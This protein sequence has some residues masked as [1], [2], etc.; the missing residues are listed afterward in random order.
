MGTLGREGLALVMPR[1]ASP[2]RCVLSEWVCHYNAGRPHVALGPGM[3]QPSAA[4]PV[5]LQ[6]YR[7]QLPTHGR[8]VVHPILG[9]VYYEDARAAQAACSWSYK[10][11]RHQSNNRGDRRMH[12]SEQVA[13]LCQDLPADK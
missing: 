5:A 12:V 3:P 8:V 2:L 4:L 1:T 6:T 13:K 10:E 7:H 11:S 9:G